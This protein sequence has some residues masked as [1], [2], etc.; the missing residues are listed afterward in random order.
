M[1]NSN[2]NNPQ[3]KPE[4]DSHN[5]KTLEEKD[6]KE[7]IE[8]KEKEL[9]IPQSDEIEL[10]DHYSIDD[11]SYSHFEKESDEENSFLSQKKQKINEIALAIKENDLEKLK[12]LLS[13]KKSLINKKTL[14]GFSYIQYAALNGSINCFNYL[15]SLNLKTDEDIEG[16]HLIHLSLMKCI[17]KRYL[18]KCL[19]MFVFIFQNL[20]EQK[21]RWTGWAVPTST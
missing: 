12:T 13:G 14:D 19:G 2:N 10:K 15:L 18:N 11:I 21:K 20:P 5:I 9:D 16:F 8:T 17:F 3:L 7:V 6:K 4:N 1:D